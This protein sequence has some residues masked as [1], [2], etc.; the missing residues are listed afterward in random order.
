MNG[1]PY[2]SFIGGAL[3]P[4]LSVSVK[5]PQWRKPDPDHA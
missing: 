2:Q 5:L 4:V 1:C 3:W